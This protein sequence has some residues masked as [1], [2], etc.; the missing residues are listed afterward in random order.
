MAANYTYYEIDGDYDLFGDGS[1]KIIATPGHTIGHQSMKSNWLQATP[2][3]SRKTRCGCRKMPT[4]ML[5][6]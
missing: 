1:V 2:S 6:A 4:V 3:S 5:L